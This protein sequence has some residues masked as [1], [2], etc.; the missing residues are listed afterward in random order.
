MMPERDAV[1]K[2]SHQSCPWAGHLVILIMA[3]LLLGMIPVHATKLFEFSATSVTGMKHGSVHEI[4]LEKGDRISDLAWNQHW[5]PQIGL[6]LDLRIWDFILTGGVYS[7]IPTRCGYLEDFDYLLPDPNDVSHYSKHDAYMDKDVT[8]NV[9]LAFVVSLQRNYKLVPFVGYAYQ[10]RKWTARDGYLQYPQSSGTAWT[11]NEPKQTMTGTGITY[12]QS[13]RYLSIGLENVIRWSSKCSFG[14]SLAVY[15]FVH[16][17]ALDSHFLRSKQFYDEMRSGFGGRVAGWTIFAPFSDHQD[18]GFKLSA[19][20][21]AFR[22]TGT[23]STNSIGLHDTPFVKS[24]TARS[25]TTS[26][27]FTFSIEVIFNPR[28]WD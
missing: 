1:T 3:L 21:E 13:I 10:N 25:K 19:S 27:I 26:S 15:P 12:E 11:G 17:D 18:I 22:S 24:E 16:V 6:D 5:S 20:Y 23:T 8:F 2:D 4:V 14:F 9:R 7:S 28:I